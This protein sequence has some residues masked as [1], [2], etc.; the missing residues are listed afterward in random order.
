MARPTVRRSGQWP[1]L[2]KVTEKICLVSGGT[3]G[4]GRALALGLARN[5]ARVVIIGRTLSGA[6]AAA[7]EIRKLTNNKLVEAISADLERQLSIR[8]LA[9]QCRDRFFRIDL[10]AN[11][12]GALF[13]QRRETADGFEATWA[14]DYLS[15]FLL[16][17]LLLDLIKRSEQGRIIT[18]GGTP[19]IIARG[20]IDL[21]N[22]QMKNNYH[23]ARAAVRAALARVLFSHELARRLVDTRIMANVFNPG[24]VR[25]KLT[26]HLPLTLRFLAQL[27]QP[28]LQPASA[29][30]L[31][32]AL[33]PELTGISG[34][35][36]NRKKPVRFPYHRFSEIIV[37]L[38]RLSEE[39][40]GLSNQDVPPHQVSTG[41]L[42][43]K[44]AGRT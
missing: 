33:A 3:S 16:T 42:A 39:M 23:G 22:P 7:E 44:A 15:H 9:G 8:V 21:A 4:V 31:H 37:P 12:A 14:V 24:L 5:N 29:T 13:P 28:L 35:F 30:A 26:R 32:L 38:W 43:I 20:R 11:C 18:V 2:N 6:E 10:L 40:T 36:F 19:W 25:S 41:G 17:N 34:Q 27:G 1:W